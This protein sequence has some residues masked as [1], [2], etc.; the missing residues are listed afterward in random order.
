MMT[1]A[2]KIDDRE[3]HRAAVE[4]GYA[5]L[6]D[7]VAQ[8]SR[9]NLAGPFPTL[10]CREIVKGIVEAIVETTTHVKM[11]GEGAQLFA[12][13]IVRGARIVTQQDDDVTAERF[14]VELLDKL[15]RGGIDALREL[16]EAVTGDALV[17]AVTEP[18]NEALAAA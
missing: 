12:L 16:V 10:R 8:Y 6:P 4:A 15:N 5:S 2:E 3:A 13:G 11:T 9:P 14:V 18:D 7:Y 1:L 17:E